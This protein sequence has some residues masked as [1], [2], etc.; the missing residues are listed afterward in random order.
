MATEKECLKALHS[1]VARVSEIDPEEFSRHAV[2][3]TVSCRISD[4]GVAFN[5]RIHAEGLDPFE[6]VDGAPAGPPAQVRLT[7]G[8]DDLVALAEDRLSV[9]RAWATSRLTID[10]SFG[11]LLRLAKLL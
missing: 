5:T 4:L 3:R 7:V 11:D 8:S 2:E 6:R 1:I 9:S 10:A